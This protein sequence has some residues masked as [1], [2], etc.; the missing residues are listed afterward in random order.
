[1]N[2][3][4]GAIPTPRR[5]ACAMGAI[6]S[7]L[8]RRVHLVSGPH[9]ALVLDGDGLDSVSVVDPAQLHQQGTG[10]SS[11]SS[12]SNEGIWQ[13]RIEGENV[14]AHGRPLLCVLCADRYPHPALQ[15]CNPV[16]VA[17]SRSWTA[18]HRWLLEY[19]QEEVG[20]PFHLSSLYCRKY[21][22]TDDATGNVILQDDRPAALWEFCDVSTLV[23]G[24]AGTPE[25]KAE[26]L[27]A[28]TPRCT[29]S[30][31]ELASGVSGFR[32]FKGT[33]AEALQART[34]TPDGARA[35]TPPKEFLEIGVDI[36]PDCELA[37]PPATL[38]GVFAA[39]YGPASTFRQD[40]ADHPDV[41]VFPVRAVR[42]APWCGVGGCRQPWS[43]PFLG[44]REYV[45]ELRLAL[46]HAEGVDT[47]AV[48]IASKVSLG[49]PF[50]DTLTELLYLISQESLE[51]PVRMRS[52]GIAQPGRTREM[53]IE[54]MIDA[55]RLWVEG[56]LRHLSAF[57]EA[58]LQLE[59][60]SHGPE[61][62]AELGHA[63]DA[64]APAPEEQPAQ[65]ASSCSRRRLGSWFAA[66]P[67]SEAPA[68][69]DEAVRDTD[70]SGMPEDANLDEAAANVVD[71]RGV[72]AADT[73]LQPMQWSWVDP[74]L[75]IINPFRWSELRQPLALALELEFQTN[76]RG[77]VLRSA[78][79]D[80]TNQ[81]FPHA[82]AAAQW[83]RDHC[84]VEQT[85]DTA[86][87]V[88]AVMAAAQVALSR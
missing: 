34:H 2:R 40:I 12:S 47:M 26:A 20:S 55:R 53:V 67:S 46:C 17:D 64:M 6:E 77:V 54:Q 82:Q 52:W 33:V 13:V 25:P 87:C 45:E 7:S 79:D 65:A 70:V 81:E 57:P 19:S 39:L 27:P 51:Q 10:G 62:E 36:G 30:P 68:Q 18:E 63:A 84:T 24:R 22:A 76:G 21:L 56:A 23:L 16:R 44:E 42:G 69:A 43:V 83:I 50:G 37:E 85:A 75:G 71:T 41:V 78:D 86:Q 38:F 49:W 48:Q 4:A 11:S 66:T 3:A 60:A 15:A 59:P 1:V 5:R 28:V 8:P 32:P 14:D 73:G 74:A 72:K 61:A 9:R 58:S 31:E 35:F 80:T 29:E 88:F